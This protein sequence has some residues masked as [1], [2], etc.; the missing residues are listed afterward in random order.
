MRLSRKE[1]LE[2]L[3]TDLVAFEEYLKQL[4]DD[5][6]TDFPEDDEINIKN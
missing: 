5:E 6:I 2:L 3:K 4:S 1:E